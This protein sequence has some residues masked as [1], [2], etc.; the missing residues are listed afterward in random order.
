[1]VDLIPVL[2]PELHSADIRTE[3]P[4]L[5]LWSLDYRFSTMPAQYSLF[6]FLWRNELMPPTVDFNPVH[7]ESGDGRDPLITKSCGS[8]IID[9]ADFFRSHRKHLDSRIS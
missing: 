5:L 1:M 9:G 4:R 3:L 7:R 8:Q 2:V 6:F